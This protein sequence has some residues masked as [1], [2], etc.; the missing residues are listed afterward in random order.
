LYARRNRTSRQTK[1]L[2]HASIHLGS[3][4]SP[5]ALNAA[6]SKPAGVRLSTQRGCAAL[7][8]D[9]WRAPLRRAS[10]KK[11]SG[12]GPRE[13]AQYTLA[14]ADATEIEFIFEPQDEGGYYVYAPD[15][16][17]LHTQGETID[18]A[19]VNAREALE[20]YIE[21]LHEAGRPLGAGVIRQKLRV[22]A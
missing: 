4:G 19:T 2:K 16:P 7:C 9:W 5:S 1:F 21:G 17:G 18:E 13:T 20:L 3:H 15:L 11:A 14:M 6:L 12:N 10:P 8:G 22:P